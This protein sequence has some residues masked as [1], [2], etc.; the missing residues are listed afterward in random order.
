M[1]I[2]NNISA[3]T[4]YRHLNSTQK[5]M[6]TSLERLSSGLRINHAADDAA[7]LAISE[8]LRAQVSGYEI[9]ARNAQDGISLIQTAEGSLDRVHTILRRMRDLA[10][11]AAN[12]DKTDG[13]RAHYQHEIDQLIEE[14]DRIGNT[15]EYNTKKLLDGSLGASKSEIGDL[16]NINA[17]TKLKLTGPPVMSGEYQVEVRDAAT[18]SKATIGGL[19]ELV[20]DSDTFFS[21]FVNDSTVPADSGAMDGDYTFRIDMD[22]KQT[23]VT[24]TAKDGSGDTLGE[25]IS[26]IDDALA[27]AGMEGYAQLNPDI[28]DDGA[29]LPAIEIVSK[30]FGSA[31]DISIH[32]VNGPALT[33]QYVAAT[34]YNADEATSHAIYNSDRSDANGVIQETVNFMS[35]DPLDDLQSL[36]NGGYWD[37][38]I[39]ITDRSGNE[40][41][42]VFGSGVPALGSIFLDTD[43][44]AA[45]PADQGDDHITIDNI[46]EGINSLVDDETGNALEVRAIYDEQL[47]RIRII[48]EGSGTG[49]L[50]VEGTTDGN[51]LL[52][53]ANDQLAAKL[54]IFGTHYGTEIEGKKL[55]GTSD[56]HL[57]ITAP[58][59]SSSAEVFGNFGSRNTTFTGI[60]SPGFAVTS[61]GIDPD[62]TG[63]VLEG[64]GGIAGIEFQL[65]EKTIAGGEQF[66]ILIKKGDLV[67]QMGANG[68]SDNR[69]S[70]SIDRMT[71]DALSILNVDVT[72]QANAQDVLDSE[73][74]DVAIDKIS[75]QRAKLG[76]FTNRLNHTI[77]NLNITK[78]NLSSAES[79]IRDADIAVETLAFTKHQ[80][81]SQSG[82]MML[83][84]ATQIP[85]LAL[86]L[87]QS[88]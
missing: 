47:G 38:S 63:V 41:E 36:G 37:R 25:V 12:G 44:P 35:N 59:N 6:N 81:L 56:Y 46:I 68:N 42:L 1:R 57:T 84:R 78:E 85:Q 88:I 65:E 39:T 72:T 87:L 64:A 61:S 19:T 86:Q 28:D 33:S 5:S 26:K 69:M 77:A 31:H 73:V 10:E 18:R 9:A 30:N 45:V 54:G 82:T 20:A 22:G 66:S 16:D 49:A 14:V 8:K 11:L 3:L 79:R 71:S 23:S 75:T 80:I 70:I 32:I 21:D 62:A 43:V 48:A 2:N 34:S 52:E 24:L 51:E 60:D 55:S 67:L 27:A 40:A 50:T 4:A 74:I 7:G 29:V 76:A 13:D 53:R 15:T 17:A 58:N 83:S